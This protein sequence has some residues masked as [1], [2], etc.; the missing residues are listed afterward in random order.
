MEI[1]RDK[2]VVG[3]VDKSLPVFNLTPPT[4]RE[5]LAAKASEIFAE[6]IRVSEL[7]PDNEHLHV[8]YTKYISSGDC[9]LEVL[10]C[11][12]DGEKLSSVRVDF[13]APEAF[14]ML[15][16][17]LGLVIKMGWKS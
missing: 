11:N 9:I 6:A 8:E 17:V 7:M 15:D 2:C 3:T 4:E 10:H 13:A 16:A 12:S 5:I 1:T 14:R